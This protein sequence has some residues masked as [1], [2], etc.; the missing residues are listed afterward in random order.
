PAAISRPFS[1]I[2]A[3]FRQRQHCL[4]ATGAQLNLQF[5]SPTLHFLQQY[6]VPKDSLPV[7]P[8]PQVLGCEFI[9][10]RIGGFQI[11][12]AKGGVHHT[13]ILLVLVREGVDGLL[14]VVAEFKEQVLGDVF[15][16]RVLEFTSVWCKVRH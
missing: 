12:T 11:E 2:E 1:G 8:S 5:L 7:L 15:S 9:L 16:S 10:C 6:L 3:P 4:Y 13:L 14:S